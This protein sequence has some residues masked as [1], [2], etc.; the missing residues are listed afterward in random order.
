MAGSPA[1]EVAVFLVLG[2]ALVL[3]V[4]APLRYDLVAM[5][6]ALALAIPGIIPAERLFLGFGHP[7][8]V[9]VAAVLIVSRGLQDS[10]LVEYLSGWLQRVGGRTTLQ[11]AAL[12]A[13]V[14]ASSSFMNNV[15]ALALFLPVAVRLARRSGVPPS[16]VL[17]PI[18]FASLL[19]GMVTLIGTPPNI[20]VA[21]FRGEAVGVPFG[22]FAFAPVGLGVTVAGWER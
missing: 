1:A 19:G 3:F 4:W 16:V 2:A 14:A 15:G 9:T 7:A 8:V 6:A 17:M 22:M 20:I 13:V 12:C 11:V 18:A 5:V 21:T 10:G